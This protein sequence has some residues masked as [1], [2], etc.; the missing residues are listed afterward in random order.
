MVVSMAALTAQYLK[1]RF[2]EIVGWPYVSPGS[3][4][5][6]GID[7]SGAFVRA[8]R[9][10]GKSIYHGSN[11]IERVYCRDCYDLNGS[12]AGLE[13]GMAIFK[14]REPNEDGYGLPASYQAGG[15]NYNADLRDYTH[16]GMITGVNPLRITNATSPYAKV[17]TKLGSGIRSWRRA[18]WL[19]AVTYGTNGN[20]NGTAQQDRSEQAMD[21]L[22]GKTCRVVAAS[23]STV[24]MRKSA[25][26]SGDLVVR[27]PIGKT[28][29]VSEDDGG[30]YVKCRYEDV[31]KA[32]P[33]VG[34]IGRDY[35][36]IY[37]YQAEDG[38]TA[39]E[40][41]EAETDTS[42]EQAEAV[43]DDSGAVRYRVYMDFLT[44]GEAEAFLKGV[45]G[46]QMGSVK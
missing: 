6:N 23:G 15:A 21:E 35:L 40:T 38:D 20:E 29:L 17:D 5:K 2:D 32:V 39:Q 25:S 19:K 13:V 8:Y 30:S 9:M 45:R 42:G 16:I 7:C 3:N 43:A 37:D 27:I 18:G 33:Y 31:T 12:T 28:V 4:D 1:E 24:N 46:A 10:A 14:F 26:Q 41:D 34:Y 36:T 11:R 22:Q 44:R